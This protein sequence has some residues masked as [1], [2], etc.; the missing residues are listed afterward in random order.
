[1]VLIISLETDLNKCR[2]VGLREQRRVVVGVR[3]VNIDHNRAAELVAA[4]VLGLHLQHVARHHLPV[5]FLLDRDVA[6]G[7]VHGKLILPVAPLDRVADFAVGAAVHVVGS[8]L[9]NFVTCLRVFSD[10]STVGHLVENG[11]VVVAVRHCDVDGGV[12]AERR[13]AAVNRLH[14]QQVVLGALEI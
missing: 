3:N 2:V 5:Q 6:G 12:V 9:Q 7:W 10:A 13:V 14:R 8:N 11:R 1:M 4:E